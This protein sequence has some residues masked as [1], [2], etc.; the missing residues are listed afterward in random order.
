M[1]LNPD[2][3]V[4][5]ENVVILSKAEWALIDEGLFDLHREYARQRTAW[6]RDKEMYDELIDRIT[7]LRQKIDRQLSPVIPC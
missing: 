3:L 7:A 2:I 4:G 1:T 5:M 6:S